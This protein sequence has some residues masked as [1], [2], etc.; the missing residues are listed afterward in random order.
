[1]EARDITTAGGSS[2]CVVEV[3]SSCHRPIDDGSH[4]THTETFN[5]GN[6]GLPGTALSAVHLRERISRNKLARLETFE[7]GLDLQGHIRMT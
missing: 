1:M 7:R 5:I 4:A 3:T 2:G 6:V